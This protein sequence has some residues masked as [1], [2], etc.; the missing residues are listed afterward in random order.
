MPEKKSPSVPFDQALMHELRFGGLHKE[1][2]EELVGIVAG[3]HKVG[4]TRVKVFPIG[5]PAVTGVQVSGVVEA[6]AVSEFLR[7]VLT[8]TPRL[9][10]V[11]VFPYGIPWPEIFRVN[12]DIGAPVEAGAINEG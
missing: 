4:L 5:I 10:G 6:G 11:V 1:N 8:S 3:I 2:L 7:Q 12:I 9:G